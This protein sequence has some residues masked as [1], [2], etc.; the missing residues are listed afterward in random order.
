MDEIED[1]EALPQIEDGEW[2]EE[3][4]AILRIAKEAGFI[5]WDLG[6]VFR[7]TDSRSIRLAEWDLHPNAKGHTMVASRLYSLIT[8]NGQQV[9]HQR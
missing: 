6:D 7:G 5:V 3:T 2:Q 9:F 4:P 1:V 8:S